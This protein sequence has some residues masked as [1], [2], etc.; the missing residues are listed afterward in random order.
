MQVLDLHPEKQL[1]L[2]RN[3]GS[4]RPVDPD[5]AIDS[6][7]NDDY[8]RYYSRWCTSHSRMAFWCCHAIDIFY[9]FFPLLCFIGY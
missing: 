3:V 5:A 4:A 7:R 6:V 9:F 8:S 1:Y 2:K